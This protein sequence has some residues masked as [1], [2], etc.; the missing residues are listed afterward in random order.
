[1]IDLNYQRFKHPLL[2][3][4][5][6]CQVPVSLQEYKIKKIK[7]KT[8][9]SVLDLSSSLNFAVRPSLTPCKTPSIPKFQFKKAKSKQDFRLPSSE[10]IPSSFLR[11]Q[12]KSSK[13]Y[14]SANKSLQLKPSTGSHPPSIRLKKLLI[15]KSQKQ[16]KPA[17]FEVPRSNLPSQTFNKWKT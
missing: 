17:Y 1:M 9:L 16:V 10:P 2:L 8:D 13:N 5:N 3:S 6:Y 11:A 4:L 15:R 12:V 7:E 14:K